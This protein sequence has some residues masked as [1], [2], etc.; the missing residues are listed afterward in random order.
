MAKFKT[1]YVVL[2]VVAAIAVFLGWY[3]WGS[4]ATPAGQP[5]LTSLSRENFAQLTSSFD[6]S[7]G[8]T[9]LVLL[10]SPT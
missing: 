4:G 10:L 9:R 6:Q 8:Q 2:P 3:L 1:R 5:P 7:A